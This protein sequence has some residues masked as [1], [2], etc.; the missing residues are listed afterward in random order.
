M[1]EPNRGTF[2]V[3]TPPGGDRGPAPAPVSARGP[4]FDV[5]SGLR[6][7]SSLDPDAIL[8]LE[9]QP[10]PGLAPLEALGKAYQRALQRHGAELLAYG[11][12]MGQSLLRREVAAWLS[13]R[14]GLRVDIDQ[15][16]ITR[17]SRAAITLIS[18]ALLKDGDEVAVEE[19]GNPQVR[20]AIRHGVQ[21]RLRPIPVDGEGLDPAALEGPGAPPRLVFLTPQHQFPTAAVLSGPR[22]RRLLD[23]AAAHRLA[24]VEEDLDS[25]YAYGDHPVLPLAS[26]DTGGHVVYTTSLSRILA[27]GIRLGCIVAPASLIDRF[28][29]VQR[30]LEWQGDRAVEWAVADLMRDGELA[31]HPRRSRKVYEARMHCLLDLVRRDLEEVLEAS[32]CEGGLSLWARIRPEVPAREWIDACRIRG[33]ALRPPSHFFLGEPRPCTLI[34]F[35]QHAEARLAQATARMK[36]ALEDVTT[37][38]R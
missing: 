34:G 25:E 15:I 35:A 10:D 26:Q 5:P 28:A 23:Y 14:R 27:P 11:E 16:L 19:P 9:G 12:P 36:Q 20:E 21:V 6:P 38:A 32:P 2:V 1:T 3:E 4:G 29:R 18:L 8:M 31:R 33:V 22:R 24:L 13:E 17:G 30:N 37:R 7:L